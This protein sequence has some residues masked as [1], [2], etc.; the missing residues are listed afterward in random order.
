MWELIG[1]LPLKPRIHGLVL[2]PKWALLRLTYA[3]IWVY[4]SAM[5][6][7]ILISTPF[8]SVESTADELGVT[9]LRVKRL[10]HLMDAIHKG[11]PVGFAALTGRV[12]HKAAKK[13]V[14][15]RRSRRQR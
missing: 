15:G 7:K 14:R 2:E 6:A 1:L 4:V 12:K 8:P 5:G 10:V 9:K 11:E 13:T 3:S